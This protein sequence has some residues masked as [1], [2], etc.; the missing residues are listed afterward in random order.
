MIQHSYNGK[1]NKNKVKY[2]GIILK[3][4]CFIFNRKIVKLTDFKGRIFFTFILNKCKICE[5]E[6][7]NVYWFTN[8]GDCILNEDGTVDQ[9]SES[10]YIK[11]WEL[12][13]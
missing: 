5:K 12:V 8:V 4:R 7:C 11:K 3:I 6:H 2:P 10:S 13:K 9:L 1:D